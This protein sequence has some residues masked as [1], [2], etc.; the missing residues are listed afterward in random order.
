MMKKYMIQENQRGFLFKDGTFEQMLKPGKS[1]FFGN[2]YRCEIVKASGR[3]AM[4]G[5]DARL[6]L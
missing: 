2:G 3:F 4:E 5:F 1:R 6:F